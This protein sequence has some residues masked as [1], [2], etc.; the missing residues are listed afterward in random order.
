MSA[1][2]VFMSLIF[3]AFTLV[4]LVL[5]IWLIVKS[6]GGMGYPSCGK[7]GYDVSG[8]VGSEI[9]CPE[10]GAEFTTVG[11]V[12]PRTTNKSMRV[13]GICLL[14]IPLTCG[15]GLVLTGIMS[16]TRARSQVIMAAPV[17]PAA[18]TQPTVVTEARDA[19]AEEEPPPPDDGATGD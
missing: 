6:R 5:G 9:R 8:T 13:T 15:G 14:V 7:C 10:C 17:A 1:A 18:P 2:P 3:L 19:E 12:P 16:A 4:P 11:I